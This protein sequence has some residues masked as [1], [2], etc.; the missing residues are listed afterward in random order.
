MGATR[1][2]IDAAHAAAVENGEA[3]ADDVRQI[4]GQQDFGGGVVRQKD[5]GEFVESFPEEIRV[6]GTTQLSAFAMGGKRARSA[7]IRLAGGKV[8]LV[9]GKAFSK[10]EVIQFSGTAVVRE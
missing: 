1:E 8:M 9:D 5:G 2:A 7:S 10:G 3:T 4:P 6:D